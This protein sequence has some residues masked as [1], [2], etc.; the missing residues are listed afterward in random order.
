MAWT[1]EERQQR[2]DEIDTGLSRWTRA[3]DPRS[4]MAELQARGVM[5]VVVADG[6]DLVEDPHLAERGFWARIEHPEVGL[7]SYPGTPIRLSR[8]PVTYRLPAPTFGQH[9]GE[10]LGEA[11]ASAALLAALRERRAICEEP[12]G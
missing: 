2:H 10:V 4:L 1:L 7:R 3:R 11:G 5:S 12:P 9:N 6:R 8:T